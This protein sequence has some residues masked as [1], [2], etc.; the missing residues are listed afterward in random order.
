MLKK[1]HHVG[2]AVRDME[3]ASRF[4]R[5]VLGF[6]TSPIG[7][8]NGMRFVFAH[9]G[10]DEIELLEDH[11]PDSPIGKFLEKKGEGIHHVA[12]EVDDIR[13]SMEELKGKGF[14]FID[15]EPRIGVH[16]VLIAFIHP[17][18]THGVLTELC[19]RSR[20]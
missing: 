14:R 1:I 5:E 15:K 4:Y 12:Y 19:E 20:G 3:R 9:C 6:K 13:A 2:V 7:E 8:M 18:C 11:R 10:G 17:E 16:G